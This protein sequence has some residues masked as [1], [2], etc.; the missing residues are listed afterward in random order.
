M[1]GRPTAFPF[2]L[3]GELELFHRLAEAA[4]QGIG[5]ASLDATVRYFNPALRSLLGVPGDADL[6]RYAF[7]DFYAEPE[8]RR[9]RD[10]VIPLVKEQGF[11]TGE[12]DLLALDGR[13]IPTIHNVFLIQGAG[14]E[15]VAFANVVTDLRER[16][17]RES[18]TRRL[19]EILDAARDFIASGDAEGRLTYMNVGGRRML[20]IPLDEDVS[21]LRIPDTHPPEWAEKAFR[22][23]LP[24]ATRDGY[25]EGE[26]VFMRRDG[27]TFP[28][29]QVIVA[30][31]DAKGEI[32]QYSTIVRDISE[33]QAAEEAL[34]RARNFLE[35]VINSLPSFVFWKDRHSRF[36]GANDRFVHAAGLASVEELVGKTDFDLVWKDHAD[37][38]RSDDFQ[39]MVSGKAKFNYVEPFTLPDGRTH[40]IETSKVPLRDE[41]GTVIGILGLFHDVTERR[42]AEENLR[43]SEALLAE[44][45][46]LAHIGSWELD[47]ETGAL[48]W[49]DEIFRIFEIDQEKFGASYEAF[50]STVHPDDRE[51]VHL[52]YTE[53]V[54]NRTPYTMTHRLLMPDGRIK[55]VLEHG[56]T[57]YDEGGN[58]IRSMGSV[59][60][61]TQRVLAEQQ[62][63]LLAKVFESSREAVLIT[64]E[65]NNIIAANRAY[66]DLT[67]RREEEVK[68]SPPSMVS[69]H[70]QQADG[71]GISQVLADSGFW[72][73]ELWETRANGE[74]FPVWLAITQ[75]ADERGSV[76]H[77]IYSFSDI[78]EHK[79]AEEQIHH[80]AHHDALTNLPNR[81]TLVARLK[82]AFS[83][84][85][86][87]REKVAVM[88]I[89][90]D[91]FKN[92]NDT[93][94]HHIGDELLIQ[95]AR[96]LR[97]CVRDSDI[98]A[99]LGGD[100]FVVGLVGVEDV[101]GVS[102]VAE[103][104]R[105]SLGLIYAIEGHELYTS[106]SVGISLFP[107]DGTEIE[108]LMKNADVA[109]YHAKAQGRNNY[110]FFEAEM[111]KVA[112]ERLALEGDLR[113]ALEREE[114]CLYY[115]P[116]ISIATGRVVGV[117]ALV[118]WRH[119]GKGL[120]SPAMFIP[121]AEESGLILP[122]G[123]W[124]LKTACLQLKHW[125][126]LGMTDIQMSVN[127]SASQFR[128]RALPQTVASLVVQCDIDPTFLELEITESV[129]MDNPQQTS[130]TME[131]LRGIGVKMAIDDFGTGYSSLNYLK[132]FPLN[133]LKLDRS[134]VKDIETD[135]NDAAICAATIALA[136]NLGLDVVAEGVETE[137]QLDYLARLNCD[138][139]Q[140]FFFSKPLPAEEAERFIAERNAHVC[141]LG[142]KKDE[143]R[144]VLV[145]DDDAWI[146][147]F[148]KQ[149]LQYLGH[150][151]IVETDPLAGLEKLAQ[152]PSHFDL[153]MVDLLMP[154]MSGMDLIRSVRT[155]ARDL[156][157]LV[158]TA[159]KA[160]FVR[161]ALKPLEKDHNLLPGI[162]YFVL[163]KP[164]T[165]ED[166][167]D[168]THTIFR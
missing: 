67:G 136:H 137:K 65:Q 144:N 117:E 152:A 105:R 83:S 93:L 81:F 33:S 140:G 79:A 34:G 89:D 2:I 75:V 29:S 50:L 38:Y 52:A 24:A 49:T 162:N 23:A 64:D 91:R 42:K 39:V 125:V 112:L 146:C 94:G 155:F 168:M 119:P 120:V 5:I 60:D 138:K 128:Q 66:S 59:Q 46:Q 159:H 150:I 1:V 163:E 98:V 167:S 58:P 131:I 164:F 102:H 30:H 134:F 20:G 14:G 41:K 19:L 31:R 71:E 85:Q 97:E 100:E 116:Q 166:V 86:R 130:E 32:Y 57:F 135:P 148:L 111:N 16:K 53:S 56:E 165:V 157:I 101:I 72:Q 73:G 80:L 61:V 129:A 40:W 74:R 26:T 13:I 11:W 124:V 9:L 158:I 43:K 27:S 103:K 87:N 48:Y 17:E 92:I 142:Q 88:F 22:E 114:F 153:L 12:F 147:D 127:L 37:I 113:L 90:L 99:R 35:L 25:W 21:K 44:S 78:T 28:A 62:L 95:V 118:R 149:T 161:Q 123:E 160:E 115:Q 4:G 15:Y 104:I 10:E 156:P 154:T 110:Q 69:N 82:Q 45:Q 141:L 143:P 121:I 108:D 51:A 133:R 151:P 63:R 77:Y 55:F 109:M 139:V 54:K 126:E 145:I 18:E 84:A 3:D 122:L 96:R 132:L 68:R 7:Y 76:T 47:L 36:L 70:W 107:D 8:R 106:P 6:S